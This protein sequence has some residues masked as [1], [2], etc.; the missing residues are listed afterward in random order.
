M[1]NLL[2]LL[3]ITVL[4]SNSFAQKFI[5]SHTV[6]EVKKKYTKIFVV[7]KAKG[8]AERAE[9]EDDIVNRFKKADILAV[10]SYI[11]LTDEMLKKG[12]DEKSL[13]LFVKKLREEKFDGIVLTNMLEAKESVDFNPGHYSTTTV[14]VRYGRFGRY[15]GTVN[16]GS[17]Q[18]S[19]VEKHQNYVLESLLYDLR[20][21]TTKENSLHWIGKI[22]VTDPS[23]FDKATDKYAKILVKR[24]MQQAIEE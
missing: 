22:K 4:A 19:T 10:P 9:I 12:K 1:K 15:Y 3:F 13:E 6:G 20:G 8:P 11:L 16:V 17:Y 2:T 21:G 23:S 18:P 14:P 5:T 7:A 24:L